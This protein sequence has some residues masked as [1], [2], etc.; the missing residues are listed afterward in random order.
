MSSE[1]KTPNIP[2]DRARK[3]I[4]YSRMYLVIPHDAIIEII[5]RNVVIT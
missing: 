5:V 2:V 3:A 4:M 1:M